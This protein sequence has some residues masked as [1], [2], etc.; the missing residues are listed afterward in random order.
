MK[1]VIILNVIILLSV[2]V[3]MAQKSK[4]TTQPQT[5]T[6]P[7]QTAK[8]EQ[9]PAN[10]LGEHFARKY[11]VA[12]RWNDP[13]VAKSALYDLIVEYPGSDSLIFALAYSYFQ[14]E[15]YAS[16]V[17]VGQDLLLRSPKNIQ[18]LELVAVGYEGLNINDRALQN[19]ESLFLLTGSSNTLYKMAFLQYG[20]K[21][22][23]ETVTNVDILL[24][25]PESETTK[26]TFNDAAG[27]PKEYTMKVALLNLKGLAYKDQGDKVNAKKFFDQSL[28]LA[29]DFAPAKENLVGLK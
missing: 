8:T 12:S 15:K 6:Q 16:A 28:V 11:S 27:K 13:E 29:P 4:T 26:V 2:S 23:E 5:T 22:Y 9:P 19:Y 17:L 3:V 25:K 7:A 18:V 1:K 24:G 10:L 20:L 21:R 14:D